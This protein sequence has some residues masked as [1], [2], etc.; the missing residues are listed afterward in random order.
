M[1][2]AGVDSTTSKCEVYLRIRWLKPIKFEQRISKSIMEKFRNRL[3][4]IFDL[5]QKE[6]V[7]NSS[8]TLL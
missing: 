8:L 5:F 2:K 6:S 7:A 1:K 3:K 4:V